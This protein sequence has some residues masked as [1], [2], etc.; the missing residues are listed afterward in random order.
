[1]KRIK[2]KIPSWAISAI[3]YDDYTGLED[4]EIDLIQRWFEDTGYDYVCTTDSDP[5]FTNYPAFGLPCDVYDCIC[6]TL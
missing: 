5:Y 4:S 2:E 1:M 6:V 3:I